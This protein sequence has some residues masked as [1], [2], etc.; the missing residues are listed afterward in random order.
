MKFANIN[1]RMTV[2][3]AVQS[4]FDLAAALGDESLADPAVALARWTEVVAAVPQLASGGGATVTWTEAEIG[5]PS[6]RPTQI[7][8]IGLNYAT[9]AA[10]AGLTAPAHPFVFVKTLPSLTG[11]VTEVIAESDTVDW[12]AEVTVVMGR[13][14]RHLTESEAWDAIAGITGGQD[15]SDRTV[16]NRLGLNSQPTLGKSFPGFTPTGPFLVTP[17]EFAD[18]NAI[19]F[20]CRINDE[21]VQDGSTADMIFDIPA[22]VAYLSTVVELQA[23]D[24]ILTGTPQGV[25]FGMKP[26]RYLRDGDVVTTTFEEVGSLH[27]RIV[28]RD[29]VS[30]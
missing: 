20:T 21:I 8:A 11:P 25:G 3:T 28:R 23:G 5:A 9:H 29:R 27:Q 14:V 26:P 6:P 15:I 18:R 17:D 30:A 7:F 13:T 10:E 1:G 16:Q 19:S 24:L 2:V 4:G 12:E 22:L